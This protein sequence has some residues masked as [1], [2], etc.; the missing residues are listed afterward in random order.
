M[1]FKSHPDSLPTHLIVICCHAI[2]I[3]PTHR[4]LPI[5]PANTSTTIENNWLISSFQTNETDTFT[6]HLKAGLTLL[7]TPPTDSLLVIS[8]SKTRPEIDLS[9]AA[10][11]LALAIEHNFWDLFPRDAPVS[12]LNRLE[13]PERAVNA[14]K[15]K[16]ILDEQALD[17]FGNLTFSILAFWRRTGD[18]PERITIVSHGFKRARFLDVHVRALGIPREMV[19]FVGIDP[20][21]MDPLSEDFDLERSEDVRAGERERGLTAWREDKRGV[22]RVLRG[23]RIGRNWWGI[24][25][26]L[27]E[28]VEERE[29]SGLQTSLERF[30]HQGI[31]VEVEVLLDGFGAVYGGARTRK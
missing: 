6:A 27:F 15:E 18:W 13:E 31:V 24:G 4:P 14:F 2:Y 3:P 7:A 21:Y 20:G 1:S 17:S 16:I 10:S 19:R 12:D 23:K 11:Y 5:S 8:G 29:R 30:D 9:E 22:G 26:S 28:S 25:Q